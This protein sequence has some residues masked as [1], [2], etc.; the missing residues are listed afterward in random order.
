M[1]QSMRAAGALVVRS[2]IGVLFLAVS[3]PILL[4]QTVP[5]PAGQRCLADITQ[6]PNGCALAL[7]A[8]ETRTVRIA[9]P[10]GGVR[11][12]TAEQTVGAVELYLSE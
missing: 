6:E 7:S 8:L 12:F 1:S 5:S 9:I 4:S 10:A 2:A 11:M 3:R